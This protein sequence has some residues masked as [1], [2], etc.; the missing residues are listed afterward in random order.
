M[1]KKKKL[2][3]EALKHPELFTEADI[4][5]FNLWLKSKRQHKQ[6]KKQEKKNKLKEI[7]GE[8]Q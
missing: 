7:F 2:A 4:S 1:T 8:E 3:E 5:Y 6:Q